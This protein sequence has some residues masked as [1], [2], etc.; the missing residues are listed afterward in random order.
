MTEATKTHVRGS[1][2]VLDEDELQHGD[3]SDQ[4]E[5]D[6]GTDDGESDGEKLDDGS[7]GAEAEDEGQDDEE[8]DEL[9]PNAGWAEAMAK[10]LGK[11]TPESQPTILLKNKQL[12]KIKQKE[13]QE[14]QERKNQVDKKRTWE[15][16]CREKP[17]V[18]RDRESERNL[19]RIATRGV[20]Q[21]FNAVRKHQKTMDEKVKEVGGSERKKAKILSTV[22][23]KDFIDVLRRS[24]AGADVVMKRGKQTA[25]GAEDKPAWSVLQEDFM[26]GASMKDW[27]KES[28]EEEG[29]PESPGV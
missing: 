21:L 18:V 19:Q 28:E 27:D 1:T 2:D 15:M 22:S 5:S 13:K 6:G 16:M 14:Q 20:V 24:E 17:D 3:S 11:K 26:M 9:N 23:K 25:A 12:D 4:G 7:D 8:G 10:V 29:E